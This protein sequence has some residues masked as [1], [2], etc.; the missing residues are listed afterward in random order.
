MIQLSFVAKYCSDAE[1]TVDAEQCWCWALLWCW[2]VWALMLDAAWRPHPLPLIPT[3]PASSY[4]CTFVNEIFERSVVN[5]MFYMIF[6]I[7][8]TS[9]CPNRVK[10]YFQFSGRLVLCRLPLVHNCTELP[11]LFLVFFSPA[12]FLCNNIYI[13]YF[14]LFLPFPHEWK[15]EVAW[16]KCF[17]SE[18]LITTN[19][20]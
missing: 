12:S 9:W 10:G 18:S 2:A 4:T 3:H 6:R 16:W 13:L 20:V 5:I 1:H 7:F 19:K 15:T 14:M 17:L 8:V 11:C